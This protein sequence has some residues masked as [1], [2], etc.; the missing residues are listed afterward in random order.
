MMKP[1]AILQGKKFLEVA[2]MVTTLERPTTTNGH[3][4]IGGRA[5]IYVRVSSRQQEDGAS[6]DV[7]LETCG[8][9][10]ASH[11]LEIVGKFRD[12]QSG[13]DIDRPQYQQA[14]SL[15]RAKGFDQLV[16]FRYDRTGRDD[17][18]YAGM[19]RDFAKLGITLVSASG[20]SPDPLYQKLAGVLA[21]DESRRISIRTSGSKM[22]R[23]TE[24]KWNGKTPFGYSIHHLRCGLNDCSICKDIPGSGCVLVPKEG[25]VDLVTELFKRYA[26]GGHTLSNL[27]AFLS[28]HSIAKSR[29]AIQYILRNQTYLGM[30]PHGKFSDSPFMPKAEVHWTQGLHQALTDEETFDRVQ[31]RLTENKSRQRGGPNAKY[32]FSGLVYCGNCGA[33]FQARVSQ[34]RGN[35]TYADYR[36]GRKMSFGDCQSHSVREGRI[37]AE[38][39]P[40]IETLLGRLK[41]ED[42]RAAV[43]EELIRQD[44]ATLQGTL[45]AKE[46]LAEKQQRLEN[47]L[48][49]LEDDYLD[50]TIS[51]ERYLKRRGE[52]MA[53]LEE[54]R[55]QLAAKPHL[56]LPDVEQVLAIADTITLDTLDDQAWRDIVESMVG[57]IVIEGHDIKVMWK[58]AY[59]P[60]LNL[61]AEGGV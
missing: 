5:A 59:E 24:G 46:S 25:E 21:W 33:K 37:R 31:A 56:A 2:T 48:S 19:L 53:Q 35:I 1:P 7:Q 20:E 60:L 54:I 40:P 10:C 6:L 49:N 42:I 36:C 47:R 17:A 29:Y 15:A 4:P 22:K 28:Q 9:Y 32:L 41:Q 8:K 52:I 27:R 30:V 3:H 57:R 18:E 13:L 51:K 14:L 16:V 50:R 23:Y 45:Q 26:S 44:K 58:P 12:V 39:I 34:R 38:V 61:V 11:F 55:G 43:R